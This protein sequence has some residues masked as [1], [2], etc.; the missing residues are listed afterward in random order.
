MYNRRWRKIHLSGRVIIL[1]E[2]P[3]KL[4]GRGGPGRGQ[5]RKPLKEDEPTLQAEIS[6]PQSYLEYLRAVG[7]GN[8]S[9]AVRTLVDWHRGDTEDSDR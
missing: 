8:V 9:A 7:N 6:L 1:G 3:K 2:E 5:G 4:T